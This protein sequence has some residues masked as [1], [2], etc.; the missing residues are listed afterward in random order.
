MSK[1]LQGVVTR[2]PVYGSANI[3]P[4]LTIKAIGDES[5]AVGFVSPLEIANFLV[6]PVIQINRNSKIR[7]EVRDGWDRIIKDIDFRNVSSGVKP[8]I[9]SAGNKWNLFNGE[10][11]IIETAY[12]IDGANYINY[13]ISNG[14]CTNLPVLIIFNKTQAEE[15]SLRYAVSDGSSFSIHDLKNKVGTEAPRLKIDENWKCVTIKSDPFV[16][17]TSMGYTAAI[18]ILE[19]TSNAIHHIIV[20]SKSISGE[21]DFIRTKQGSLVGIELRIRKQSID[22]KSPYEIEII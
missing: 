2:S 8:L 4:R 5:S 1:K 11:N 12:I 9:V 15:L 3:I 7:Q 16:I 10:I 6:A 20:G 21:L 22:P 14:V 19:K 13:L 18:N 17:K